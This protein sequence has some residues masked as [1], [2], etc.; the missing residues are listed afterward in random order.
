MQICSLA[1]LRLWPSHC[2]A[3]SPSSDPN[4]LLPAT[5]TLTQPSLFSPLPSGEG[6]SLPLKSFR[7]NCLRRK[8]REKEQERKEKEEESLLL[9]KN[10]FPASLVR[11]KVNGV[12]RILRAKLMI[13]SLSSTYRINISFTL[14]S[15]NYM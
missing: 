3:S 14:N 13:E 4:T 10:Y 8:R 2:A 12:M 15:E 7:P 9:F 6:L 1:M 5:M 11:M